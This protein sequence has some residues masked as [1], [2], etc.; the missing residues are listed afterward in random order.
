MFTDRFEDTLLV[1]LA[2]KVYNA[3][4]ILT[5]Y[6]RVGPAVWDRFSKGVDLQLWYYRE[7]ADT[8]K[9]AGDK[10]PGLLAQELDRVVTEIERLHAESTTAGAV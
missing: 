5:D 3:R 8:F 6:M 10:V 4:S 1:S 9:S 2:D 7:L